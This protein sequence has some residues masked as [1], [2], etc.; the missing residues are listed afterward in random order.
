MKTSL[1]MMRSKI[2][3]L[4][5]R[6]AK[7]S[8]IW[9][10][11][12]GVIAVT[13]GIQ[14]FLATGPYAQQA[15]ADAIAFAEDVSRELV[16]ILENKAADDAAKLDSV[17]E[18]I[19]AHVDFDL[20]GKLVLGSHWRNASEAERKE[21]LGL[22]RANVLSQI[23]QQ[24]SYYSGQEFEI[25]GAQTLNERDTLVQT[26]VE[27]QSGNVYRIDWRVRHEGDEFSIIDFIGEGISL[28]V[29]QRNEVGETVNRSG[30]NGLLTAMR[31]KLDSQATN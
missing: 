2:P 13:L 17:A 14:V 27:A 31:D 4:P 15:D 3:P 25:T 9:A 23:S 10:R 19:D 5:I 30:M 7:M 1:T 18:L 6:A 12:L 24:L 20:V 16:H 22:F 8:K 11:V 28:V 26:R 29:T 21:Y